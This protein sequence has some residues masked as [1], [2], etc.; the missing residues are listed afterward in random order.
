[1]VYFISEYLIIKAET[2]VARKMVVIAKLAKTRETP[3]L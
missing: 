3:Q 1:M 2:R